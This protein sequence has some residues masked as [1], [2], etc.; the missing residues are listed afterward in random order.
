MQIDSVIIEIIPILKSK[1]IQLTWHPLIYQQFY[2][3]D[4][5]DFSF[6]PLTSKEIDYF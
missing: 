5:N 6:L 3:S 4:F 2:T 1:D